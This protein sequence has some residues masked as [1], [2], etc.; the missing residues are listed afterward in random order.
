MCVQMKYAPDCIWAA[1]VVFVQQHFYALSSSSC[2]CG[3]CFGE[4]MQVVARSNRSM[5]VA[6]GNSWNPIYDQMRQNH[7]NV[8]S[9]KGNSIRECIFQFIQQQQQL[10]RMQFVAKAVWLPSTPPPPVCNRAL[11]ASCLH[12][13][14]R[15]STLLKNTH[16]KNTLWKNAYLKNTLW[17]YTLAPNPPL[18]LLHCA[19]APC[20]QAVFT[21]NFWK[22]HFWE[23]HLSAILFSKYTFE[24]KA[25]SSMQQHAVYKLSSQAAPTDSHSH[26]LREHFVQQGL[27]W[28]ELQKARLSAQAMLW[29]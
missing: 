14:L 18:L 12:M 2:S 1:A 19:T 24:K 10:C 22:L 21:T 3:S 17:K 20:L 11:S 29:S 23:I 13:T 8:W 27:Q 15:K 5:W 25:L 9:S 26:L 6:S 28:P 16:W 4:G 7:M